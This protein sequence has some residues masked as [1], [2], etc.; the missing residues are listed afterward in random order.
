MAL[1][2][3]HY[4]KLIILWAWGIAVVK[5]ILP[6]SKPGIW[7]LIIIAFIFGIAFTLSVITWKWLSYKQKQND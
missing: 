3:W 5:L 1:K 2:N 7:S 6:L 4:G